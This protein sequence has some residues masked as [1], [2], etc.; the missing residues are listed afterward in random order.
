MVIVVWPPIVT[1]WTAVDGCPLLA[2]VIV[3]DLA[4]W[5]EPLAE[6]IVLDLAED[7]VDTAAVDGLSVSFLAGD[8]FSVSFF[9][10]VVAFFAGL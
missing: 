6:V 1:V 8:G 7:P 3:F 9:S 4:S 2:G 5:P 10:V